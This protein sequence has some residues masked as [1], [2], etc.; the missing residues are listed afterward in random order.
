MKS[1]FELAMERLEKDSGPT[2]K[3]TDGQ[4]ARIAEIDKKYD[5]KAAEARLDYDNCL[6]SAPP[7]E[8]ESV[9]NKLAEALASIEDS[10]ER[11]KERVWNE[12]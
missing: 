8:M 5:A 10:R 9:R 3:L 11:D 2:R 12:D 4:K 6:A 7:S 1:A